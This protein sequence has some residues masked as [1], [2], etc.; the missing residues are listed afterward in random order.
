MVDELAIV[1]REDWAFE[2]GEQ[3]ETAPVDDL[4]HFAGDTP[5][6][7]VPTGPSSPGE[8]YR[9]VLLAAIQCARE[10]LT[11]TTPYFVPDEPTLVSLMMAADRGVEVN[12]I[13]PRTRRP[14]LHRRRRPRPLRAS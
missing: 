9:R 5:M 6:Q 13:V 12:L 3:L 8:T 2:T 1:F 4:G 14:L 7:V 10:R 11:L